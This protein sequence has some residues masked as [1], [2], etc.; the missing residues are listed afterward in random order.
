MNV[1]RTIS[2]LLILS[3]G[4]WASC[5]EEAGV[6]PD[7][8]DAPS[9]VAADPGPAEPSDTAAD[10]VAD[11]GLDASADLVEVVA[12]ALADNFG[13]TESEG[14]P[15]CEGLDSTHCLFPFPWA[16][17]TVYNLRSNSDIYFLFAV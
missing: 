13:V 12:D 15:A 6:V 17:S 10:G 14:D 3:C 1:P 9:D 7:A 8:A 2:S 4:F 11:V 5:S 16:L